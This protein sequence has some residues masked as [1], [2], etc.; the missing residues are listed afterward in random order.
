MRRKLCCTTNNT[1]E[2]TLCAGERNNA[3]LSQWGQ[4]IAPAPQHTEN[5]TNS[6]A[7]DQSH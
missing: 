3:N 2:K 1:K 6:L 5:D 7:G 4:D